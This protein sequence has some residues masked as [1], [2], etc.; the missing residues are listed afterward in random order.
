MGG[1]PKAVVGALLL[2]GAGGDGLSWVCLA[3]AGIWC[4][5]YHSKH[6]LNPGLEYAAGQK[7]PLQLCKHEWICERVSLPPGLWI[8][9]SACQSSHDIQ[10][11]P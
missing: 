5:A 7:S 4:L 2:Q 6:R 3:G 10:A 8:R 9:V 11:G 1:A